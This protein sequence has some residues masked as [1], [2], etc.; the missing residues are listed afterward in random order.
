MSS[1]HEQSFLSAVSAARVYLLAVVTTE[2][3]EK[4]DNGNGHEFSIPVHTVG[5]SS[6]PC[7]CSA[8]LVRVRVCVCR[9]RG[10]SQDE[11]PWRMCLYGGDVLSGRSRVKRHRRRLCVSFLPPSP[12]TLARVWSFIFHSCFF[13]T[14]D[15]VRLPID[16]RIE[17]YRSKTGDYRYTTRVTGAGQ[18][19]L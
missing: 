10:R 3:D 12:G 6:V 5:E 7:V 17:K 8:A 14:D 19:L 15:R 9:T 1:V 4:L 13:A 18:K 11:E 2:P 16:W